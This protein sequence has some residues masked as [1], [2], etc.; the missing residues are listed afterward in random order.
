MFILLSLIGI[1]AGY[2]F[3]SQTISGQPIEIPPLAIREQDDLSK[4]K[5][6]NLDFSAFDNLFYKSL[7]VF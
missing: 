2:L 5:D 6:V 1:I 3:Y 7:R 4:F